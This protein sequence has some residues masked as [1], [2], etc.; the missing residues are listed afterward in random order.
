[1]CPDVQVDTVKR[2]IMKANEHCAANMVSTG[3]G[4]RFGH[5]QCYC[6]VPLRHTAARFCWVWQQQG[7][8]NPLYVV[9]LVMEAAGT[10]HLFLCSL[11]YPCKSLA[12]AVARLML[13]AAVLRVEGPGERLEPQGAG[14]HSMRQPAAL[15]AQPQ[16]KQHQR[17]Q[18]Q[19][20]THCKH[21]VTKQHSTVGQPS[22]GA[23]A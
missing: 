6:E 20:H 18:H 19:L 3:L 5:G 15:E 4:E 9:L 22:G 11:N 21:S 7:R 10:Q 8:N 17:Q 16:H 2:E 23:V 14:R 12:S 1:V 13:A